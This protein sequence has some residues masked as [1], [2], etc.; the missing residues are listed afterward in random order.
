[1]RTF[2][3]QIPLFYSFL[4]QATLDVSLLPLINLISHCLNVLFYNKHK[5]MQKKEQPND[6]Y[7]STRCLKGRQSNK[8]ITFK[9][10]TKQAEDEH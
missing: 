5:N 7:Q 6:H 1:M 9:G 3:G 2:Q 8:E 4:N 10:P